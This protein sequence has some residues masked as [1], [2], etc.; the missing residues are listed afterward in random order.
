MVSGFLQADAGATARQRSRHDALA[1]GGPR[2][3]LAWRS[4]SSVDGQNRSLR[5]ADLAPLLA[6]RSAFWVDLQY[7]DTAA[8]R[9]DMQARYG[10][11]VWHDETVDPLADMDAAAAQIAALDLVI[12]ASNT[13]VHLA[14]A[15]G[16]PVWQMLPAPGY[17]LVWYWLLDRDDSPFYPVLRCFRQEAAAE[18]WGG[19]V[20][21]V[22]SA[23]D[24]WL[25]SQA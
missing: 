9:A 25:A 19:T 7:G 16:V 13:T 22:A 15:L 17:G 5:L 10:V 1:G 21:E 2:I 12:A 23:L 6:G 3:G 18:G 8:E 4:A 11:T 20:A 24:D 14:A